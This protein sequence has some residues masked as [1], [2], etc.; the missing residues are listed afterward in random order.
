[1]KQVGRTFLAWIPHWLRPALSRQYY[2]QPALKSTAWLL[3]DKVVRLAISLPV[4]LYSARYFGVSG[5]GKLNYSLAF[6]AMFTALASAGI[7]RVVTRDLVRFPDRTDEILGSAFL[8]KAVSGA[9]ALLLCIASALA[10]GPADHESLVITAVLSAT[11]VMQCAGVVPL[12]FQ[13]QTQPKPTVVSNVLAL[14]IASGARIL[15]MATGG[16]IV[17]FASIAVLELVIAT[18][19][20]FVAFNSRGKRLR[21]FR[22]DA[23]LVLT[24]LKDS[25]PLLVSALAIVLYMR[26]DVIMLQHLAG[27]DAVG[28]YTAAAKLSEVWY[29]LPIFLATSAFPTLIRLRERDPAEFLVKLRRF[30]FLLA[31]LAIGISLP[32]SLASGPAVALL[33]GSG[34]G[35]AAPVLA[36]HLWSSVAVFLGIGS[37]QYLL[38]ENL[39]AIAMYR[40]CIGLVVN[41]AL[42]LAWIP[43]H[44]ALGAAWATLFSYF[45]ATFSLA[46]FTRT[47]SQAGYLLASPFHRH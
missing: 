31:W 38:I 37:S 36:V 29:T 21:D 41:V 27:A 44:G 14:C 32:L 10:L 47:R 23:G 19:A 4:T 28:T 39:Q 8:L 2:A 42:N 13:S 24:M 18:L 46:L 43:S 34:Y 16:S 33:Y 15:V 5:F 35:Q 17:A 11:L 6:V 30:Y 12:W 26:V 3:A 1:M 25:W 22:V 45:A 9:V 20:N 7:D 40:T